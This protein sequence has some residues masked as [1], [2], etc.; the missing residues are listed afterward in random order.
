MPFKLSVFYLRRV[1]THGRLYII[2]GLAIPLG[3]TLAEFISNPHST[4]LNSVFYAYPMIIPVTGV[5]GITPLVTFLVADRRSGFYEHLF[6]TTPISVERVFTSLS[7]AS[8]SVTT[9]PV[10]I[11]VCFSFGVSWL[12]VPLPPGY[13]STLIFYTIPVSYIAPLL[14]LIVAST[15]SF[16]TR[17]VRGPFTTAP[18]G[19][20][21]IIG[22]LIVLVP[23]FVQ[24][25]LGTFSLV[26][27]LEIYS[28]SS[29]LALL[30]LATTSVRILKPERFLP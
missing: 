17:S 21:P 25:H 26:E 14:V 27:F 20:A 5:W 29:L 9:I 6:A 3:F 22:V 2:I 28:I 8:V 24:S 1:L 13:A 16:T 7:L 12:T 18:A 30:V 11:L 19:F 23:I 4:D 10:I 15:W